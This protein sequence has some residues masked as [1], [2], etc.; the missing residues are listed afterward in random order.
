[1]QKSIDSVVELQKKQNEILNKY[2][3]YE[4]EIYELSSNQKEHSQRIRGLEDWRLKMMVIS[5]LVASLVATVI[6]ILVKFI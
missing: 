3:I 2:V 4:K 6:G 1:M 5:S